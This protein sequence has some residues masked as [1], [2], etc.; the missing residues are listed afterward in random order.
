M[1]LKLML[2]EPVTK[3][4]MIPIWLDSNI[5]DTTRLLKRF[6]NFTKS[7]STFEEMEKWLKKAR[8][9]NPEMKI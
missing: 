9:L 8:R 3:G 2:R 6:G 7:F 4:C 5:V 1:S